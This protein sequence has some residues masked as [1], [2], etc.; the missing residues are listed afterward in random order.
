MVRQATA[1]ALALGLA[2]TAVASPVSTQSVRH[3]QIAQ[4]SPPVISTWRPK[5]AAPVTSVPVQPVTFNVS[6]SDT[7]QT[8][9]FNGQSLDP[10]TNDPNSQLYPISLE[11]QN[12]YY[13][14]VS[15]LASAVGDTVHAVG[16]DLFWTSAGIP[17][18][19]RLSSTAVIYTNAPGVSAQTATVAPWE[20]FV[21]GQDATL[22]GDMFGTGTTTVPVFLSL[23]GLTYAAIGYAEEALG[24]DVF[25]NSSGTGITLEPITTTIPSAWQN[26]DNP[27]GGGGPS[28]SSGTSPVRV[29]STSNQPPVGSGIA[30]IPEPNIDPTNLYSPS[31]PILSDPVTYDVTF[32]A[33][34]VANGGAAAPFSITDEEEFG[35]STPV[36]NATMTAPIVTGPVLS[37]ISSDDLGDQFVTVTGSGTGSISYTIT[38]KETVYAVDGR[39]LNPWTI[40][41]YDTSSPIYQQWANPSLNENGRIQATD[42]AIVAMAKQIVGTEQNPYIKAWLLFHWI[43]QNITYSPTTTAAGGASQVLQSRIG[44]C[45]DFADLYVAF[46]RDEG[47]PAR[48]VSGW[49]ADAGTPSNSGWHSWVEFYIPGHGW[50]PADPTWGNPNSDAYF[51]QLTDNWHVPFYM[52]YNGTT[53]NL[54]GYNNQDYST[55]DPSF[56][57]DAA[58]AAP[59][60]MPTTLGLDD[61][62]TVA[63]KALPYADVTAS[64]PDEGAINALYQAG[65]I[66]PGQDFYP[67]NPV[68]RQDFVDWLM[69]ARTHAVI[70]APEEAMAE[71]QAAGW[72]QGDPY[73]ASAQPTDAITRAEIAI[74]LQKVLRLRPVMLRNI[75]DLHALPSATQAA[76]GAVLQAKVWQPFP[77]HPADFYPTA[78][79]ARGAVAA[80][81]AH[82]MTQPL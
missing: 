10:N 18:S 37:S 30:A 59:V 56:A 33:D 78:T 73:T 19:Q 80:L 38:A 71:A 81:I 74:L 5:A 8:T 11:Y 36:S 13:L 54:G 82:V 48:V 1:L 63:P 39:I 16:S 44:I 26:L 53:L 42:P 32:K 34:D 52:A 25:L 22:P 40:P 70:S 2:G 29:A 66:L 3:V 24:V 79:L 31:Q 69:E 58:S 72:F 4:A 46:L 45:S 55:L 51:A 67:G 35:L 6:I 20:I 68:S 62:I 14:P 77:A 41:A 23:D 21:D 15:L 47:I 57:V 50:L 60:T 28:V 75:A 49:L 9:N 43:T 12:E 65:Y 7:Y 27:T 61:P 64:T 17:Y 76:I